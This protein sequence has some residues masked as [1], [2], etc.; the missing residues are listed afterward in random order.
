MSS[1]FKAQAAVAG[2]QKRRSHASST[3]DLAKSRGNY[4]RPAKVPVDLRRQS[5]L[6]AIYCGAEP[7]EVLESASLP[8]LSCSSR[9]G[10]GVRTDKVATVERP[11][12]KAG[13]F[14]RQ[15]VPGYG[16]RTRL[17]GVASFQAK[18]VM[19]ATERNQR[20]VAELAQELKMDEMNE[21]IYYAVLDSKKQDMDDEC[22]AKCAM[23]APQ[24]ADYTYE[25]TKEILAGG[26]DHAHVF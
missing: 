20:Q 25:L 10:Y 2:A 13:P 5:P 4:Y 1:I 26:D 21:R 7:S 9:S 14:V 22:E 6:V 12:I 3:G 15:S 16:G 11:Q 24:L 23:P 17:G 19:G 8:L 18:Q